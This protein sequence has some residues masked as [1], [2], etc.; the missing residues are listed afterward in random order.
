[1]LLYCAYLHAVQTERL[2]YGAK[3]LCF[4]G[5]C[6]HFVNMVAQKMFLQ[7][8]NHKFKPVYQEPVPHCNKG[9]AS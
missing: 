9:Q 2:Q 3:V 5:L 6:I 4:K 7:I 1:M 8:M